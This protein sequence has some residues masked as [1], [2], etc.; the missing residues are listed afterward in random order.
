MQNA[1]NGLVASD[2]WICHA[3]FV[4]NSRHL[5]GEFFIRGVNEEDVR[6]H[7]HEVMTKEK[8]HPVEMTAEPLDMHVRNN[9]LD[10]FCE[11]TVSDD[12]LD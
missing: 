9:F 2:L 6:D 1:M 10:Y 8:C 7:V 3:V 4:R 12:D 11:L 5:Q